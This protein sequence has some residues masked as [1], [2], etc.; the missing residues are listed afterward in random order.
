MPTTRAKRAPVFS[1]N[2]Q[3]ENESSAAKPRSRQEYHGANIPRA[4]SLIK[5]AE[6]GWQLELGAGGYNAVGD[7][8]W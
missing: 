3:T 5:T 8:K 1:V 7:T 2:A 4:I 6:S